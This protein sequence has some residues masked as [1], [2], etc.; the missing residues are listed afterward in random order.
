MYMYMYNTVISLDLCISLSTFKH[1][2]VSY[3]CIFLVW[4]GYDQETPE[5]YRSLLQKSPIQE[6]LFCKRD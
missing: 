1:T 2:A 3:R 5:N 6:T 4:G